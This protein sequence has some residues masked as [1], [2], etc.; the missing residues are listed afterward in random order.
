[1][2]G[3]PGYIQREDTIEDIPPENNNPIPNADR[4]T[5]LFLNIKVR[6]LTVLSRSL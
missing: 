1:M 4:E 2:A 5:F 6:F 3:I